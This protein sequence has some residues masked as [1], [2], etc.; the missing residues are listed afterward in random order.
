[1]QSPIKNTD[2]RRPERSEPRDTV[3]SIGLAGWNYPDWKET[4]YR[5]PSPTPE[6]D[7]FGI[8]PQVKPRYARDE[9]AYICQYVDMLEV[10]SSFYRIPTAKAVGSW[11]SRTRDRAGFFFTA[12][13]NQAFTHEFRQDAITATAFINAFEPMLSADML[14]GILCQFRYDF[15]DSAATRRHLVW[16]SRAFSPMGLLVAEVRHKSWQ[17]RD[18]LQF[19]EALGM[20]VA[21]LDYPL[22]SDSF[23][24]RSVARPAH[25][26]LRLH[27]R[28]YT[29]W[30]A[31]TKEPHDPYNYDY[32][33]SE[34][35]DL[36]D[37][38]L[39]IMGKTKQLTIVANNHYRGKA[40]SAAARLKAKLT[41]ERVPVP[42]AVLETFPALKR[43]ASVSSA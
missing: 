10:N 3:V 42:P 43:I 41:D 12:K 39:E 25:A 15:A 17:T 26:Y 40:V 1:M 22:A 8:S 31:T 24:A 19:L 37:R 33:D 20:V 34:I 4:V 23:C 16:I 2:P 6:P 11:V 13:L 38:S 21:N 32:P 36:A 18:A 14:Q 5:L 30:F 35:D 7:L 28:N 29:G 9:L 27:G